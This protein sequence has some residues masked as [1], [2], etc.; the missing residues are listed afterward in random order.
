MRQG[1]DYQPSISI[2]GHILDVV[3]DYVYLGSSIFSTMYLDRKV[4]IMI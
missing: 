2:D 1:I 3:D 4:A